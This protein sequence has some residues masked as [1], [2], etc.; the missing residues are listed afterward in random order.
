MSIRKAA[1]IAKEITVDFNR[2]GTQSGLLNSWWMFTNA[3]IQ[4]NARMIR[5]LV[6]SKRARVI[7]AGLIALGFVMDCLGRA[8]MG[9]DDETGMK[10]WDEI[11][12]FDKERNWIIPAPWSKEG[13]I[14]I[15]M[16]QGWLIFN[17]VGRMLSELCFS[18]KK[19]DPMSVA[20]RIASLVVDSFNP[21]GAVG[22]LGQFIAPSA[23]RP[24]IQITENKSFTG[25]NLYREKTAYGGYTPP[26][27]QR[28]WSSTPQ[29]WS[30]LS[31]ALN[32]V[33][34]GDDIRSGSLNIPPE[35]IQTAIT[36]F[37][38]PGLS[39]NIDKFA[40][41]ME[42]GKSVSASDIPV[43]SRMYRKVP[44]ERVQER[45]VY[46]RL[47][48]LR[49]DINVIKEYK[50]QGRLKEARE[51]VKELGN[52]DFDNGLRIFK[53]YDAFTNRLQEMNRAKRIA[54]KNNNEVALK[55]IE[56][57][58]K[59]LFADFLRRKM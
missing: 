27:Y 49:D 16:A 58:R 22:S 41:T 50:K 48:D 35:A 11:S 53:G 7:A 10:K 38:I 33:S 2:R 5:A 17:N 52:G 28:A 31:K 54:E 55:N 36:S 19:R 18:T 47:S 40:G 43:I 12:E 25:N 23:V 42:R 46:D 30:K 32:D 14:K 20:W 6:K 3:S 8:V 26:A 15:P 21:F 29:H 51:G 37:L 57:A 39:T 1:V 44:D 24:I 56:T 45:N 34:G 4:G 13:I 59:R 9:D